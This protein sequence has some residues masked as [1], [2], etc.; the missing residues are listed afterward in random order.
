MPGLSAPAGDGDPTGAT[1]WTPGHRAGRP[2]TQRIDHVLVPPG[3]VVIAAEV[4][5]GTTVDRFAELSD[6]LPLVVHARREV[7]G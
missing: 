5:G 2:P 7:R 3:W 1:N 4:G 6:H